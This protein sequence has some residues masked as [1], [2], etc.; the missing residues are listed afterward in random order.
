MP[1]V[2]VFRGAAIHSADVEIL[3]FLDNATLMISEGRIR[4]FWK[5][6][7]EVPQ[8]AFPPNAKIL[9]LPPGEFLIPGFVDTHNHGI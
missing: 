7:N 4:G 6:P 2:V 8:D 3:E 5:T 1:S 9:N